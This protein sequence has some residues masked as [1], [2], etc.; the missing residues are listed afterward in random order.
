MTDLRAVTIQAK[1][2]T[3]GE[4]GLI[5]FGGK[6][7]VCMRDPGSRN[8]LHIWSNESKFIFDPATSIPLDIQENG[9]HEVVVLRK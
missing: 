1:D 7:L 8:W 9:T 5:D 3:P 2:M 4:R 6:Q